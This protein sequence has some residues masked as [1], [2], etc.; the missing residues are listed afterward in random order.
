MKSYL[1][2]FGDGTT[3]T[4]ENPTHTFTAPG[5][6]TV[7]LTITENG[8]S[9]T[10]TKESYIT[11]TEAANFCFKMK[12][13]QSEMTY[14]AAY[15][16]SSLG[17]ASNTGGLMEQPSFGEGNEVIYPDEFSVFFET[18]G[19][20][21]FR[22]TARPLGDSTTW[23]CEIHIGDNASGVDTTPQLYVGIFVEAPGDSPAFNKNA[24]YA[25]SQ[26]AGI[27]QNNGDI[28]SPAFGGQGSP[29][30]WGPGD[31]LGI[32][33]SDSLNQVQFF[34]NGEMVGAGTRPLSNRPSYV[35]MG[36]L[37]FS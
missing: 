27:Y 37:S 36:S 22:G 20:Q 33:F 10:T 12:T 32:V 5:V 31:I 30:M 14:W 13:A 6:F 16:T 9:G 18:F 19:T 29:W 1:W 34:K 17:S 24:N 3:S 21:S 23:A 7:A 28:F 2:N 11:V 4:L 15:Q 25:G 35:M 26:Y 8:L